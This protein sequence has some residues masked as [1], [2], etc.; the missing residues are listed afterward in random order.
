MSCRVTRAGRSLR[1]CWF[2]LSSGRGSGEAA[3]SA[4]MSRLVLTRLM[5]SGFYGTAIETHRTSPRLRRP[6]R[7]A[8]AARRI[9][10]CSISA[11]GRSI[12]AARRAPQSRSS[13]GCW[14]S[15]A[16]LDRRLSDARNP[17]GWHAHEMVFGFAAAI[18]AGFL[19]T[20]VRAWTGRDTAKRR[21]ARRPRR[22]V[23]RARVL[24]W[25]G[26]AVPAASSTAPFCPSRRWSCCASWSRQATGAT[27]SSCRCC[28]CSARS[29]RPFTSSRSSGRADLA[30]RC[31][32]RGSGH[33]RAARQRDRRTR[34]PD[35]HRQRDPR[36]RRAQMAAASSS[37]SRPSP[38]LALFADAAAIDSRI[39]LVLAV[40]ACAT[41]AARLIGWRSYR[42]RRPAILAVLHL[43]YA[44]IP[45]GFALLALSRWA[46]RR[47]ASRCTRSRRA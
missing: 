5:R 20:A 45:L 18:V 11:S 29:T 22:A 25:S 38:S 46:Q 10:R 35:V 31:H 3:D 32:L 41:H 37:R 43:A 26:P 8:P 12:C 17:V 23:A 14:C 42:V 4:S 28:C 6:T 27:T 33:R 7:K 39:V 21:A 15:A 9:P 44:W 13:C 24:V 34:H 47:T 2:S 36:L 1:S 19:L 40:T 16:C 30:M